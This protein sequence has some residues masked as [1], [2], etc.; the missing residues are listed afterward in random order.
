M[1]RC[2]YKKR[3]SIS[4]DSDSCI[5][6]DP[7]VKAIS[8][9][10]SVDKCDSGVD[11][12]K[13]DSADSR[14]DEIQQ[15]CSFCCYNSET[16]HK[17]NNDLLSIKAKVHNNQY[18]SLLNFHQ[19]LQS[20]I[21]EV[22]ELDLVQ[23]Y[24]DSLKKFFPWFD[25]DCLQNDDTQD[26][27]VVESSV[28]ES[29][30]LIDDSALENAIAEEENVNLK[31]LM[32]TDEYNYEN[33]KML[34]LR[35]CNLC[36]GTGE[37][38]PSE[39]GRLIYCG[40]NE[41]VHSNCALWSSEVFEEI[42]GSL[43]NVHSA[44]SRGRQ[45]RCI[46]CD[47]KGASV[48]CCYKNCT[49]TYHFLCAKKANCVFLQNRTIYCYNHDTNEVTLPFLSSEKDFE[50]L[51]PVYIEMDRKKKKL[52][53]HSNVKLRIGSLHVENLGKIDPH[54]SDNPKYILPI[55]FRCT[56][57]FWSTTKPW[58][59]IQYHIQ[60]KLRY[61]YETVKS[62]SEVNYTVD[63]STVQSAEQDE[64]V[65]K[66]VVTEVV[67]KVSSKDDYGF[68]GTQN[69]NDL[70]PPELQE[71]IYKDLPNDLLNDKTLQD[72]W[73][74][75][76]TTNDS[77]GAKN[78][79][80][81]VK[82]EMKKID[83]ASK[84]SGLDCTRK[85]DENRT[86]INGKYLRDKNDLKEDGLRKNHSDTLG[87]FYN[88]LCNKVKR[89]INFENS[90]LN[91][92]KK[93]F[94]GNYITAEKLSPIGF[95]QEADKGY[96]PPYVQSYENILQLDGMVDIHDEE[97]VKC[98]R[99]HRTYR[100]TSSFERHLEICTADFND[101][102]ISS[103]ESDTSS[104]EERFNTS[105]KTTSPEDPTYPNVQAKYEVI[106]I[107]E[108]KPISNVQTYSTNVCDNLGQNTVYT[109]AA[110]QENGQTVDNQMQNNGG[111][112]VQNLKQQSLTIAP[113]PMLKFNVIT[114]KMKP[115]VIANDYR[116]QYAVSSIPNT[117]PYQLQNMGPTYVI[118]SLPKPDGIPTYV[119]V[120]NT[121]TECIQTQETLL[122]QPLQLQQFA[123]VNQPSMNFQP[124][125]PT[126][127]GTVM[128]PNGLET[129][130]YYI[131]APA[132]STDLYAAQ[133]NIMLPNQPMLFGTETMVSNTVMSQSQYMT[134][135]L[136]GN[137]GSST[138]YSTM[139]TQVFQ[140]AKQQPQT[141]PSGF[142][143]VNSPIQQTVPVQ[144]PVPMK[145]PQVVNHV[146]TSSTEKYM[147]VQ[148]NPQNV[149]K[150]EKAP[151]PTI[152]KTVKNHAIPKD[153]PT[154]VMRV[155]NNKPV[156]VQAAPVNVKTYQSNC[157]KLN[158]SSKPVPNGYYTNHVN[159][160]VTMPKPVRS[161]FKSVPV[162]SALPTVT[163]P[164]INAVKPMLPA[165]VRSAPKPQPVAKPF[166]RKSA[167]PKMQ[168][169]DKCVN[170]DRKEPPVV[171]DV[172]KHTIATNTSNERTIQISYTIDNEENLQLPD[173]LVK[174]WQVTIPVEENVV[175]PEQL[176]SPRK[177]ESP[178]FQ[179]SSIDMPDLSFFEQQEA[180]V[181]KPQHLEKV[182][183]K[184]DSEKLFDELLRQ[185]MLSMNS[186]DIAKQDIR[187]E[188]PPEPKNCKMFS[189]NKYKPQITK[190]LSPNAEESKDVKSNG[191]R[192]ISL[193]KEN[194][195]KL[196]N[197]ITEAEQTKNWKTA[198]ISFEVNAED[199]F[200]YK[201]NNLMDLW[202]KIIESVQKSRAKC[203][204]PLL[205][206]NAVVNADS[207]YSL[208]G[209]ENNASKYLLEQL[210]DAWKCIFY[211]PVFHKSPMQNNKTSPTK[212]ET[213]CARTE[214]FNSAHKYDM[215]GWLASR[216]RKPPKFMMLS[217][218]DIVNG[219]R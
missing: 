192:K 24:R 219:N 215:F 10:S 65:V 99:C 31:A 12:M 88:E 28:N 83:A 73:N 153:K 166:V 136:T 43:Q 51:R 134:Q 97:P 5:D 72:I 200:N 135:S 115:N 152:T 127:L 17:I 213:G 32:A 157:I 207:V 76:D 11:D 183:I 89:K 197:L 167:V 39:G 105:T 184:S 71:A 173:S 74:N 85:N 120:N 193:E 40:R 191:K 209:F 61:C 139:T 86:K 47:K 179:P 60:I 84:I 68:L 114:G 185:H 21:E 67:N 161:T 187:I 110:V 170:T 138:M 52:E 126:I 176:P 211:K 190:K 188:E 90:T 91:A 189:K 162:Q 33:F 186:V 163:V 30:P 20:V 210:P 22:E 205:P 216:H 29:S 174:S 36:K 177:V 141:I 129:P 75:Y 182:E 79:P 212:N 144:Q 131:N 142:I 38:V 118:Q 156:A 122:Q 146:P 16:R 150:P 159:N 119:A 80:R 44:I 128:Q 154:K 125:I 116:T 155:K 45:I 137:M 171:N 49:Q 70:L 53:C 145:Q 55:Y 46:V 169:V 3:T 147:Y 181:S 95:Y 50:I 92:K 9:D 108:P 25:P 15:R 111:I 107:Q 58:K 113:Q 104:E 77:D 218:S 1:C 56:R 217:D 35:K 148:I 143:V 27:E 41:W 180:E 165:I 98:D 23:T 54:L 130:T 140:A 133:D 158:G 69:G 4:D 42:D 26:Y 132:Q 7:E 81:T 208:L 168:K 78:H 206:K 6:T 178:T 94:D 82:L 151:K 34:D 196:K 117:Q 195:N 8:S 204:L 124:V 123:T 13:D 194:F 121:I 62:D 37:A 103:C 19:E 57:L 96:K 87:N 14:A 160:H 175:E 201:T 93:L 2:T 199:G 102:M 198:S 109:F 172:A 101:Y 66:Q 149:P 106:T 18:S 202:N 63:H 164:P 203:K 48:G 112:F 100:T 214:P 64:K 59:I